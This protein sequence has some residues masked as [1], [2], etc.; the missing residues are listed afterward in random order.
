MLFEER[1]KMEQKHPC[2]NE[3]KEGGGEGAGLEDEVRNRVILGGIGR[4]KGMVQEEARVGWPS[5]WPLACWG[6]GLG[7]GGLAP[8]Y[9]LTKQS[10]MAAVL[11]KQQQILNPTKL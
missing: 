11:K 7:V 10:L 1:R 9:S 4:V 8:Q 5:W 3:V 2:S 6:L